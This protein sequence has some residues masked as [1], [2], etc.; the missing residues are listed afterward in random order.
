MLFVVVALGLLPPAPFISMSHFP[1]FLLTAALASE[2]SVFNYT[3]FVGMVIPPY[4]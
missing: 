4:R 1:N 2:D 3:G